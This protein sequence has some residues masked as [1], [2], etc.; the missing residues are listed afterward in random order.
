MR[1]W[2]L[3]VVKSE[4]ILIVATVLAIISCFVVPPDAEYRS[5]VHTKTIAQLVCL[6]LVVC[7]FQRIGV[8]RMVGSRLLRMVLS[9]IHI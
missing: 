5:Y 4:T 7:G 9:L 6:M 8:F 1:R 2:L 3:E